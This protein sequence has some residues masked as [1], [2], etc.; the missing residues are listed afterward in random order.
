[1]LEEGD[2][3]GCR[4][5]FGIEE[6]G[7][8]RIF[9]DAIEVGVVTGLEAV[10]T[11]E[12]DGFGEVL[13]AGV[14]VA[15]EGGEQGEAVEGVVGRLLFEEDFLEVLASVFV[16]AL[17]EQG[18]GVVVALFVRLE[19]GGAFVDLCDAGGDIHANAVGEILRRGLEH[20][21]EGV[22]G[23]IVFAGLHEL[24]RALVEGERGLAGGVRGV[25]CVSGE[26]A[27]GLGRDGR[28]GCFV[29]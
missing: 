17:V 22:V 25:L 28:P 29:L 9:S 1:M 7:E 6:F 23:L 26:G 5:D 16:V 4:S 13:D 12:A 21:G 18:D 27:R 3:K 15:G 10:L 8:A 11:F 19:V 14:V 2:D 24:E 20:F